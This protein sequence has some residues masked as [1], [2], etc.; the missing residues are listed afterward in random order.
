M[1]FRYLLDCYR[2]KIF[3]LQSCLDKNLAPGYIVQRI[4]RIKCCNSTKGWDF[5]FH[6]LSWVCEILFICKVEIMLVFLWLQF[7]KYLTNNSAQL[8]SKLSNNTYHFLNL[9]IKKKYGSIT[10]TD[11]HIFNFSSYVLSDSEKFVLSRGLN[12]CAQSY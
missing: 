10:T 9:L 8:K 1:H 7:L 12:F 6:R 4:R 5:L 11:R 2:N 3:L